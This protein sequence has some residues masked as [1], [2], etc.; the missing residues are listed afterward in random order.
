MAWHHHKIPEL[1]PQQSRDL[2]PQLR[3]IFPTSA[4]P[5]AAAVEGQEFFVK[6][7]GDTPS[8]EPK[9][10]STAA[11]PVQNQRRI[12]NKTHSDPDTFAVFTAAEGSTF[13]KSDSYTFLQDLGG[14]TIQQDDTAVHAQHAAA[15][16]ELGVDYE[17]SDD[18][19]MDV[20]GCSSYEPLNDTE[21]M[22]L[23]HPLASFSG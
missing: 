18:E 11:H 4:Q 15:Q 16:D 23:A 1:Q 10:A 9:R 20:N 21:I 22:Q 17:Y 6:L 7:R 3:R 8:D 12:R 2:S 5:Q 14:D 13:G 19:D